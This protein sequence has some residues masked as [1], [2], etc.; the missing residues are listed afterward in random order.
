MAAFNAELVHRIQVYRDILNKYLCGQNAL[1]RGTKKSP[2]YLKCIGF[3]TTRT[4]LFIPLAVF[5]SFSLGKPAFDAT[6]I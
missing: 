1:L 3:C 2:I 5:F 4:L 6:L